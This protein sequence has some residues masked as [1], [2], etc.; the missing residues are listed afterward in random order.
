MFDIKF[1]LVVKQTNKQKQLFST[2]WPFT[3]GWSPQGLCPFGADDGADHGAAWETVH[4]AAW[5]FAVVAAWSFLLWHIDLKMHLKT[6]VSND[7]ILIHLFRF[8]FF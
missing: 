6:I 7:D 8:P 3:P 4:G 5:A 2:F 1:I